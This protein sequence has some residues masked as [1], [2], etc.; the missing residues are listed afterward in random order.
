MDHESITLQEPGR[1]GDDPGPHPDLGRRVAASPLAKQLADKVGVETDRAGR[2]PV[3]PDCTLPGHP[4]VFALGDMVSLN[5]L[6]GVAQPALQEGRYVGKVIKARL[7]GAEDVAPFKY[8]DKGSMATI[9]YRS[10]VADAFGRKVTGLIAYVMWAFVHV[11]YLIGW[12]NRMLTPDPSGSQPG[13]HQ[14]PQPPDH[15]LGRGL[16]AKD[17]A[18]GRRPSEPSRGDTSGGVSAGGHGRPAGGPEPPS[19]PPAE[20]R[21]GVRLRGR[22]GA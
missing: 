14:E 16:G 18:T 7:A 15:H 12:G 3:N 9:G 13:V 10:A 4:E 22:P 17:L 20:T 19:P 6:P 11:W 2:I 21:P 8:F 5:K 1:R